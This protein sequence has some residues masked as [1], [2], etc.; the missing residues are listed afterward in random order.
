MGE[1]P[2][3]TCQAHVFTINP[4][5]R[6]SWVPASSKA[7]DINFFYDSNRQCYRIVSVEDS[8]LG[9]RVVINCTITEK[10]VF[11][12]T[13][14]KF[15]QWSDSKSGGVFG[16]GFNSEADL[17]KFVSQFKQCVE[18]T[19]QNNSGTA[20][21]TI[22]PLGGLDCQPSGLKNGQSG[23][24]AASG[25]LPLSAATVSTRNTL[26]LPNPP[27]ALL[28]TGFIGTTNN[29]T[30]TTVTPLSLGKSTILSDHPTILPTSESTLL[31]Q[32]QLSSAQAQIRRL[33]QELSATR[34]QASF[35]IGNE[36]NLP[37]SPLKSAPD[38]SDLRDNLSRVQLADSAGDSLRPFLL[39][40]I[41]P[42]GDFDA[43]L[44]EVAPEAS[45]PSSDSESSTSTLLRLHLRL[46][47]L[48][49]EA[50]DL[51]AQIGHLLAQSTISS[52]AGA[53]SHSPSH[54]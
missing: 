22:K 28:S 43:G 29:S 53:P 20:K 38:G 3:F 6:K 15:G 33:E 45:G 30:A 23:E 21:R 4:S 11:K 40:G 27:S 18:T 24:S 26:P 9:K 31:L 8:S 54:S 51:H 37:S 49:R 1:L 16:L 17:I 47:N 52:T 44:I 48:L 32:Q 41:A 39:S 19:K 13:S 7:I 50:S 12:Q 10:M 36:S 46:G 2:V 14:Q 25:P 5:T 34:R 42:K 35:S